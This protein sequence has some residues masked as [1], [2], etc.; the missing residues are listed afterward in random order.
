V[1]ASGTMRTSP[2]MLKT[3]LLGSTLLV[4]ALYKLAMFGLEAPFDWLAN[5]AIEGLL[6]A[7]AWLVS[8]GVERSRSRAL[9]LL[10]DGAYYVCLGVSYLVNFAHTF[11]FGAAA[12]RQFALFDLKL[13]QVGFFFRDV[14]P[15]EGVFTLIALTMVIIVL[16][17]VLVDR[18]RTLSLP[19]AARALV[20]HACIVLTI[21]ALREERTPSPTVD[22]VTELR[23]ILLHSRVDVTA[24]TPRAFD[25]ENLDKSAARPGTLITP[26]KKIVVIVFET[27]NEHTLREEIAAL[28]ARSFLRRAASNAHVYDRYYTSNQDS[29]TGM[30]GMLSS[31]FIPYDAY[32]EAGRDHYMHLAMRSSLPDLF[33]GFGYETAFAVSQT[34]LELVVSE[35]KWQQIL[36]LSDQEADAAHGKF[37]CFNPYQF[38]HSCEDKALLPKV[39]K[40]LAQHDRAFVYQEMIWGHTVEYNEASGKSNAAYYS[41]YLDALVAA[42][43]SAG[44]LDDTLIAISADHGLRNKALQLEPNIGQVPLWFYAPRFQATHNQGLYSHLDFKDLLLHELIAGSAEI[45]D[46]PF[47]FIV[48]PTGTSFRSVVTREGGFIVFKERDDARYLWRQSGP[49][50]GPTPS[51]YLKLFDDYRHA[52]ER[53]ARRP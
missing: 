41:E 45:A 51:S 39:T 15:V 21:L 19:W 52:F 8:M 46:N 30:L 44:V 9:R 33:H 11:F 13:D 2:R 6:V 53:D 26:F 4:L 37:L 18:V 7:F 31:R 50:T 49:K 34:E 48:G 28:P 17:R 24:D 14:L 47:V 40:F 25:L 35:L 36:S 5:V 20:L 10:A 12:Q 22:L 1:V 43:A 32:T 3:A 42:L 23:G 29:R 38:E 16:A 27:T